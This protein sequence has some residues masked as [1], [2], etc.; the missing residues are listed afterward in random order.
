MASEMAAG[1]PGNLTPEQEV[2][3]K[4]MWAQ[5]FE[6]FGLASERTQSNGSATPTTTSGAS[7]DSKKPKAKG[8]MKLFGRKKEEP[9][10]GVESGND[11]HGQTQEY[12]QALTSHKPEELRA[13][14]WDMLKHD[15]PDALLLR[16]LRARKW[17]VHAALVMAVSTLHWRLTDMHVDDDIMANGEEHAL[18]SSKAGNGAE[19]KE[20]NDFMMQLRM[21]KS[22]V[23][24]TDK[25][26]RPCCYVRV[27]L[28][29]QG[30]QSEKSLERFTVF[31]IETTRL[32]LKPPIDTA[33][34]LRTYVHGFSYD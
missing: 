22:F 16:F 27:K 13:A 30:E 4:E 9:T 1:R 23:H 25:E 28:H 20:A 8:G 3:L 29:K 7:D 32:M 21:G 24:G 10:N 5:A 11:K 18:K 19:K 12:H 31:L 26:G 17:D 33:V 15:H 14:F 34:S 2:K 6:I